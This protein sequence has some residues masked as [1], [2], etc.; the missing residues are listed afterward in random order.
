MH[1]KTRGILLALILVLLIPAGVS[2][3]ATYTGGQV[4]IGQPIPDD[5]IASGGMIDVNAPVDSLI[6][7]GG[8]VSHVKGDV[9]GRR[10]LT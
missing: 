10:R 6:V 7:A 4:T 2:A 9:M 8:T 3:L 5:V 1:I